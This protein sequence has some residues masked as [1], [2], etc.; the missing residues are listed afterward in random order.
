M[1]IGKVISKIFVITNKS[2][3]S[4]NY[5]IEAQNFKAGDNFK[6]TGY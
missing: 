1:A 6:K 4:T 5:D 3:I 2:A